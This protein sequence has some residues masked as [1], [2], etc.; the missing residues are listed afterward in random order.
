[1][2]DAGELLDLS[3]LLAGAVLGAV[4]TLEEA[5]VGSTG[6]A[7]PQYFRNRTVSGRPAWSDP[8]TA[9]YYLHVK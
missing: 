1:M 8:L 6:N 7:V 2:S 9:L 3:M 5:L 4:S